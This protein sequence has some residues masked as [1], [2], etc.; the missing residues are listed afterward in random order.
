MR[1]DQRRKKII[2]RVFFRTSGWKGCLGVI[3]WSERM[4][5]GYPVVGGD[6]VFR[7]YP[8]IPGGYPNA[9]MFI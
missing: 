2:N 8:E 4:F 3:R 1:E 9:Y 5:R 6:V 7:V